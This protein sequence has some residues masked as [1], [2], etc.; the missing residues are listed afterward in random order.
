MSSERPL[1]ALGVKSE[2]E[3]SKNAFTDHPPQEYDGEGRD[4]ADGPFLSPRIAAYVKRFENQLIEYNLEARGIERVQQHERMKRLTWVSYLQAFLLWVSINLA[5]N[6]ITLGM[7]GPVVYGLSFLDSALCAVLGALVGALVAA[8]MATW[9]PVSGVRT[10]AFGRYT[11]G[12]W[13]SKIVV[14]LN[15]IQML[16]YCLID[17]VVC[18]QILSA[19]SPNGDMSVAVGIVIIAVSCWVIAT[20]G[21]QVFH[22]YERFA[23][24][25]QIIVVSILYAVSSSKFDLSTPSSGD[26]RTLA[27]N[28]LSFF[29]ICLSA[30]ITYAPLAGDFFV[31]YPERTSR[32]TLFSLSLVGLIVSFTMAFLVGIGLASG[33]SSHPEYG[34]AYSRGA[35]ALIVE[36]F[37]PLHGFGKF[38]S[39]V[40]A[41]GLIA[42][43]IPP[44]YSAGV[45]FQVLGRY[46]EKVPR[47]IWNT[48]GVIIYTVCALV[49]R[50]NLSDIFTNFLALM[51]YWVAI[52]IAI[53]LEERFIFRFRTGYNWSVWNDPSKLPVGIAAFVAFVVGWVG[54]ILCMAQVWY[55]GPLSRLV[56]EYGADMGNYVGFTWAGLVYPPLRYVELRMLGR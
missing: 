19:V 23:F 5:A 2:K 4:A 24:L 14:I 45:D 8:W 50:S 16:G 44:T 31:Y 36:G 21:Y 30:A 35:G 38:C 18:G 22:Y 49:G 37:G 28:R 51:G 13:P 1:P 17:C 7:L 12:W 41:L 32:V 15:L 55:I 33:I 3:P 39:V 10:M 42:N 53:I 25:P 52:W 46:A 20:F 40:V 48:I 56:G 29:S 47:A 27:G 11:M 9:G 6:N 34:A 43:T 26:P 54:A